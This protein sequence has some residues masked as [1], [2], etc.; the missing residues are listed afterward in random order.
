L[1]VFVKEE[2]AGGCAGLDG[3]GGEG[4]VFVMELEH[5]AKVDVADDVD[6]VKEEGLGKRVASGEWRVTSAF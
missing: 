6:V 3:Q 4:M 5:A 2:E 1:R